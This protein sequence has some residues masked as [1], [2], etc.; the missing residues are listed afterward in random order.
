MRI[1]FFLAAVLA[2]VLATEEEKNDKD[3]A[4]KLAA[5]FDM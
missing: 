4:K 3:F 2:V 1:M 5:P